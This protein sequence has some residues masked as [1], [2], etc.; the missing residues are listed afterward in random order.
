MNRLWGNCILIVG[1]AIAGL[2]HAES[3]YDSATFR[4]P[5][6]D[7]K[8]LNAGDNL[9]VL[10]YENATAQTSAGTTTEKTGGPSLKLQQPTQDRNWSLSMAEDFSGNGKIQRSGK[11]LGTITVIVKSV[12]ANGDLNIQGEQ[13]IEFNEEKQL[14]KLEGRVRPVDIQEN[15][16]IVSTKIA[17]AKISYVGDGVLASRQH[18]GLLTRFL[19]LLGLL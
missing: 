19:S 9:T 2:C 14:I 11:L 7:H 13:S 5:V 16:S 17:N 4:S 15:N 18:P 3:L 1:A 6:S 12:E 10:I 8:A